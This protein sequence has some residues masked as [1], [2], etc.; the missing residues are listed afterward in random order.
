M[1]QTKKQ[2]RAQEARKV[3]V[4]SIG[5]DETRTRYASM[6]EAAQAIGANVSQI[7]K[8]VN[9]GDKVHGMKWEREK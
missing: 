9:F 2:K 6:K 4:V 8:A 3:P 7:S 1:A 5:P